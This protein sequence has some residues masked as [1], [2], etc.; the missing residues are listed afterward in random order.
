VEQ[1]RGGAAEH[2]GRVGTNMVVKRI[3]RAG[4]SVE[5]PAAGKECQAPKRQLDCSRFASKHSC[6][7][8]S[9]REMLG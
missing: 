3:S 8:E 1:G 4:E 2:G 5:G 7:H 6:R 9:C